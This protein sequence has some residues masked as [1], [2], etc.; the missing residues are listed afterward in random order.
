M[1]KLWGESD[2][3]RDQETIPLTPVSYDHVEGFTGDDTVNHIDLGRPFKNIFENQHELYNFLS[4]L[5]ESTNDY[6]GTFKDSLE[7]AHTFNDS[8]DVIAC[9][10]GGTYE[11][12]K[13][14]AIIPGGGIGDLQNTFFNIYTPDSNDFYVW[15]NLDGAGRDPGLDHPE[16]TDITAILPGGDPANL[17]GKWFYLYST[18]TQYYIWFDYNNLSTDPGIAPPP[19][20]TGI[21]ID[22]DALDTTA[23]AIAEKIRVAL[24]AYGGGT[25]FDA[26]RIAATV[27]VTNIIAGV[28]TDAADG[29]TGFTITKVLDGLDAIATGTGI[30]SYISTGNTTDQIAE[31]I[32]SS[33]DLNSN[34][35]AS[36][37]IPDTDRV[38]ITAVLPG[39]ATDTSDGANATGFTITT[40]SQGAIGNKYYSR[41]TPG[42]DYVNGLLVVLRP[43]TWI[44]ERQIVKIFNLESWSANGEGCTIHYWVTTDKYQ[45]QIRKKD[46]LNVLQFYTFTNGGVWET[47]TDG[48]DTAIEMLADVYNN[49]YTHE[50]LKA[51]VGT[52]LTKILIEPTGEITTT[53]KKWWVVKNDGEFELR[54]SP[55][56]TGGSDLWEF[57]VTI[58]PPTISVDGG[59]LV[60]HRYFF[61]NFSDFKHNIFLNVPSIWKT[62]VDE[63]TRSLDTTS[64]DPKSFD[65]NNTDVNWGKV[66]NES[67]FLTILRQHAGTYNSTSANFG[68]VEGDVAD[69]DPHGV[70][71]GGQQDVFYMNKDMIVQWSDGLGDWARFSTVATSSVSAINVVDTYTSL[72][73]PRPDGDVWFVKDVNQLYRYS[74]SIAIWIPISDP[75]RQHWAQV[76]IKLRASEETGWPGYVQYTRYQFDGLSW[77][78]DGSNIQV[79]LNGLYQ[80]RDDG[81][82]AHD[83]FIVNHNTIQFNTALTAPTDKVAVRVDEGGDSFY[84]E[85]VNYQVGVPSGMYDGDTFYFN[86]PWDVVGDRVDVYVNGILQHESPAIGAIV[87][88]GGDNVDKI[89]STTYTFTSAN[90]GNFILIRSA[91]N[92]DNDYEI[93]RI[94]SVVDVNTVMLDEY[95][96]MNTTAG[97][98][99]EIYRNYDYIVDEYH[100][101]IIFSQARRSEDFVELRDRATVIGD[102]DMNNHGATFPSTPMFGYEFFRTDLNSWFKYDGTSW[103]Q[104]S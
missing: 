93:R 29:D 104:I 5:A 32:E 71:P 24:L 88:T 53:G 96:P 42:I 8:T 26:T 2:I 22:I 99:Y 33:I 64:T 45:M 21:E 59:S 40:S 47:P 19:T 102:K 61:Q 90:I 95:F 12:T 94:A 81:V 100:N 18:T 69:F 35:H 84:P 34:F 1:Y 30:Q 9:E 92:L 16:I 60:D 97:D 68:W 85:R 77:K 25:V 72:P 4:K 20:G 79:Y 50:G 91:T 101:R 56:G 41:L 44:A 103:I 31:A 3:I 82:T 98:M 83:Y 58:T 54:T 17:G 23:D 70:V 65:P 80:L 86:T 11:E 57:D 7:H 55:I 89:V 37:V 48:Y 66:T 10:V 43:Q 46:S 63:T 14:T 62:G 74:T 6:V 52:D 73:S 49:V 67:A 51:G 15:M 76:G 28:A 38:T 36:I 39:N 78:L 75:H 87:E 27:T 13:V